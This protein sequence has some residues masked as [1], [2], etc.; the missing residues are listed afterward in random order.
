LRGTVGRGLPLGDCLHLGR[1]LGFLEGR[2]FRDRVPYE[3]VEA[4]RLED[5]VMDVDVDEPEDNENLN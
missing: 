1:D 4:I 3:R 2:C 5:D